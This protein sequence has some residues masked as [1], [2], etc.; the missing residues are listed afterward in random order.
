MRFTCCGTNQHVHLSLESTDA[1]WKVWEMAKN[2]C[3]QC[4]VSVCNPFCLEKDRVNNPPYV[5]VYGVFIKEWEYAKTC[6]VRGPP[7]F[8][9]HFE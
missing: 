9:L 5:L 6:V 3:D 4:E 8:A 1:E 7:A 2:K